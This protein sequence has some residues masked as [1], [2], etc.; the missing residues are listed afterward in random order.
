MTQHENKF[1][2][3]GLTL[4][5]MLAL[6]AYAAMRTWHRDRSPAQSPDAPS[7]TYEGEPEQATAQPREAHQAIKPRSIRTEKP[8]T[9]TTTPLAENASSATPHAELPV[10]STVKSIGTQRTA[11][12]R[13]SLNAGEVLSPVTDLSTI[14]VIA[15]VY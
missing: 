5:L 14:W 4:G 12:Q 13:Q 6:V 1:V 2:I 10:H 3:T 11:T 15:D 9:P 7:R 8:A